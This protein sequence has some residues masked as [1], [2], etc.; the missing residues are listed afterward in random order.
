MK[1][2]QCEL[3]HMFGA[4]MSS[5]KVGYDYHCSEVLWDLSIYHIN[6]AIIDCLYTYME[7]LVLSPS[8]FIY[9]YGTVS[10]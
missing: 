10:W 1:M 2:I 8:L 9:V 6:K 4:V 5:S 3:L 7:L